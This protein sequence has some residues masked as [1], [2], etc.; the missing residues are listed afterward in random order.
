MTVRL[1][2]QGDGFGLCTKCK[3]ATSIE[4]RTPKGGTVA[5]VHCSAAHLPSYPGMLVEKCGSYEA[6]GT[7]SLF[8]MKESAWLLLK[9]RNKPLGFV[10]PD[11][12]EKK[13]RYEILET[14]QEDWP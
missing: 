5:R 14:I 13:A 9:E 6:Y 4:G 7:P 11:K 3:H 1:R 2:V 10:H 12:I 8:E